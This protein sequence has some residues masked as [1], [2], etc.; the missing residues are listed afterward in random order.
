[1]QL[2]TKI[3][4]TFCHKCPK[5]I[6]AQN[7]M[8]LRTSIRQLVLLQIFFYQFPHLWMIIFHV[9]LVHKEIIVFSKLISIQRRR[10]LIC[11][12]WK[13]AKVGQNETV[14]KSLQPPCPALQLASGLIS[15]PPVQRAFS[16]ED[17]PQCFTC[18]CQVLPVRPRQHSHDHY[19]DYSWKSQNLKCVVVI[20]CFFF[21]FFTQKKCFVGVKFGEFIC[22]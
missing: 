1:M 18:S 9:L 17:V 21:N 14:I 7:I 22:V 20:H 6:K 15:Y 19:L 3:S 13:S 2:F 12:A 5:H 16:V 8:L 10:K 11:A 4:H